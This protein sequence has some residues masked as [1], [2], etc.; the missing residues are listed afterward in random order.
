[1][2]VR[3]YVSDNMCTVDVD[4]CVQGEKGEREREREICSIFCNPLWKATRKLLLLF[5]FT[6]L[7]IC[8]ILKPRRL[9]VWYRSL[10]HN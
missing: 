6:N 3:E 9:K 7:Q 8:N 2:Y 10:S 5:L 4:E 1:M